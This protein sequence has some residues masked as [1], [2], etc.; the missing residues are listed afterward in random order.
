[1]AEGEAEPKL[2]GLGKHRGE[3]VGGKILELVDAEVEVSA[4]V[5]ELRDARH[6]R[7]L[8]LRRQERA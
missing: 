5:F 7:E 2:A 6:R 8:K 4:F 3:S 1:M